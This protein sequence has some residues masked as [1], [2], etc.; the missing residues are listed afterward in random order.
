M[1]SKLMNRAQ[2]ASALT[3]GSHRWGDGA[4]PLRNAFTAMESSDRRTMSRRKPHIACRQG[5]PI[6][7]HLLRRQP[8]SASEWFCKCVVDH[9][10]VTRTAHAITTATVFMITPHHG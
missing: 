10:K 5:L 1:P 6:R 9:E 7:A 4:I 8:Q 2:L 3:S